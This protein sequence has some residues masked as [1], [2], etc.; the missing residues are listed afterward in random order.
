MPPFT[1]SKA[2]PCSS[3]ESLLG[4]F[5]IPG[6]MFDTPAVGGRHSFIKVYPEEKI[7]SPQGKNH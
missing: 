6:R 4:R 3:L 1:F 5:W 2:I 7:F